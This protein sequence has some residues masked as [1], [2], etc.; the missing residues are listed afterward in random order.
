VLAGIDFEEIDAEQ[1]VS[2]MYSMM[3]DD[4]M[5]VGVSRAEAREAIDKEIMNVALSSE[6]RRAKARQDRQREAGQ[7]VEPLPPA[8]P[9]E[10][11]PDIMSAF[12]LR[13]PKPRPPAEGGEQG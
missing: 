9:L 13:P 3:V 1:T 11:S 4:V 7:P 2:L 5:S 12:G 6:A 10:L 8:Q